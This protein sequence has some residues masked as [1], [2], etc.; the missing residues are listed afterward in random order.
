VPPSRRS[1]S[2]LEPPGD[3]PH[4]QARRERDTAYVRD[5]LRNLATPYF[6]KLKRENFAEVAVAVPA[7][8]HAQGI[9]QVMAALPTVTQQLWASGHGGSCWGGA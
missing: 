3:S 2:W 4:D 9:R 5:R 6:L 1:T 8:L 7:F